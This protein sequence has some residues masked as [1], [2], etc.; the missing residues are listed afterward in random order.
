MG[1]EVGAGSEMKLNEQSE[2]LEE[3]FK[4][5]AEAGLTNRAFFRHATTSDGNDVET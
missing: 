5:K 2:R 4:P 1:K 3:I